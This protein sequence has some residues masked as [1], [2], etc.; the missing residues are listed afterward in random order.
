VA[1]AAHRGTSS[2]AARPASRKQPRAIAASPWRAARSP[3]LN[4]TWT[5]MF[6]RP[7]SRVARVAACRG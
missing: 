2:T 3:S 7:R 4:G 1:V 6:T 5:S